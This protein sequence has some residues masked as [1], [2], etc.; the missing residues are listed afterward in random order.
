[1]KTDFP[2]NFLIFSLYL[3]SFCSFLLYFPRFFHP[4]GADS[5]A[6][7]V[8]RVLGSPGCL[9]C[10]SWL[11][12]I[13]STCHW[14]A[15]GPAGS[16]LGPPKENKLHPNNSSDQDENGLL[17]WFILFILVGCQHCNMFTFPC[18]WESRLRTRSQ[19][20][21]TCSP[22]NLRALSRAT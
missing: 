16:S 12:Q 1:M 10:T 8:H 19:Q 13:G 6:Y 20:F 11:L 14:N 15:T 4:G 2:Y 3:P 9:L 7:C 22:L 17:G 18:C 21:T 5:P